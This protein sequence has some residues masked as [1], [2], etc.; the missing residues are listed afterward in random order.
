MRR[1]LPWV[2]CVTWWVSACST[3]APT[4][5]PTLLVEPQGASPSRRQANWQ[6]P[7]VFTS[8]A[9]SGQTASQVTNA[10][11]DCAGGRCQF[12]RV[13]APGTGQFTV[14]RRGVRVRP[15]IIPSTSMWLIPRDGRGIVS[16]LERRDA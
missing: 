12:F 13:D 4:T 16:R 1:L 10:D 6:T 3:T 7:T 8:I 2:I 11:P 14:T 5:M 15:V 9:A